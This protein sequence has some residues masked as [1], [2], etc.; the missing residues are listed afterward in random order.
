MEVTLR[1]SRDAGDALLR[2]R[3]WSRLGSGIRDAAS[4]RSSLMRYNMPIAY[5]IEHLNQS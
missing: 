3:P 5:D 2:L 1:L 4:T